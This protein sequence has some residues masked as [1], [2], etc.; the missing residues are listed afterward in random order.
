MLRSGAQLRLSRAYRAALARRH[1]L[2]EMFVIP[3]T[4][5]QQRFYV[6]LEIGEWR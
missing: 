5:L 3:T 1:L 2:G 6:G 4:S